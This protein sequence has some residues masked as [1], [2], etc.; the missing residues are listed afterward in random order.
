MFELFL[1]VCN[2]PNITIVLATNNSIDSLLWYF[3]LVLLVI[4][5]IILGAMLLAFSNKPNDWKHEPISSDFYPGGRLNY[6]AASIKQGSP[7]YSEYSPLRNQIQMLFF[8]KIGAF[9]GLSSAEVMDMK[10]KDPNRLRELIQDKELA[11]W[12]FN[13]KQK[14]QKKGFFDFIKSDK[15]LEKQQ[16][17]SEINS[18]LDKMEV[19]GG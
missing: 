11:D 12:I 6:F 3:F 18:I 19:W 4:G 1:A 5:G 17:I 14:K 2:L 13:F 15:V 8:E 9:H 16:Y 10:I 7:D